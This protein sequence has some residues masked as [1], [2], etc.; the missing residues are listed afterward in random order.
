M[1]GFHKPFVDSHADSTTFRPW[2]PMSLVHLHQLIKSFRGQLVLDQ[3]DLEVESGSYLVLL[4]PS[5][6]G[7]TTTLRMIAGLERPDS[8]QVN[9][10]GEN[11]T[12]VPPRK[13]DVSMVFQNDGLYPHLTVEQTLRLALRGRCKASEVD[14]RFSEA[15]DLTGVSKLLDRLPG[16]MSGGELRR[17]AIATAIA[18]KTVIR[19]FDEPMSALDVGLREQMQ[20]DLVRWHH[21]VPGATIHVTHDGNEAMRSADRIAVMGGGRILQVGD[22]ATVY[23]QP[24]EIAVAK[25]IGTPAM[26]W[27]AADTVDG[28]IRLNDPTLA[29]SGTVRVDADA[30][31]DGVILGVR[32]GGFLLTRKE[33]REQPNAIPGLHLSTKLLDCR[34]V[35]E[36]VEIIVQFADTEWTAVFN[37][38]DC[39][40]L[41]TP[42]ELIFLCVPAD[43]LHVFSASTQRR[44]DISLVG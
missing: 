7:K 25:A 29:M 12:S 21:E 34:I 20:R 9:I 6:C 3:F 1:V 19:L 23:D 44:L 39:G 33:E 11:V 41:P 24:Q 17:A 30:S 18:K 14:S 27:L 2:H 36:T 38:K 16:Q 5:G 26:N 40:Q 32:P 4:G 28:W 35:Q 42:G 8:G 37:R 10:N 22:P 13:R 43:A 15:V 31:C